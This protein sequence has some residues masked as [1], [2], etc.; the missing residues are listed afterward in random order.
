MGSSSLCSILSTFGSINAGSHEGR[1]ILFGLSSAS[2]EACSSAVNC[3]SYETFMVAENLECAVST[4]MMFS[5]FI[6][7]PTSRGHFGWPFMVVGWY[8]S[9]FTGGLLSFA[10]KLSAVQASSS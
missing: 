7:T 5:T 4:E 1:Q 3:H 10:S 9:E 2:H 6:P 8:A